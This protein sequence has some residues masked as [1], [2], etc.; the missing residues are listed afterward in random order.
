MHRAGVQA[1][2]VVVR[3][4]RLKRTRACVS[5]VNSLTSFSCLRRVTASC[6]CSLQRC[7]AFYRPS[8]HVLSSSPTVSGFCRLLSLASHPCM[9]HLLLKTC[10]VC[11]PPCQQEGSCCLA[12]VP[13][14]LLVVLFAAALFPAAHI[15]TH[16]QYRTVCTR[17]LRLATH[18][19]DSTAVLNQHPPQ[20][21][22]TDGSGP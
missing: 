13:L 14:L 22:G 5:F 15:T 21:I 12:V 2:G 8:A 6:C 20:H 17:I 16:F 18:S 4:H 3:H 7:C 19:L 1:V 9:P 11:V 10:D